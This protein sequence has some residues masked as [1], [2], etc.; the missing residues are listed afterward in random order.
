MKIRIR[1]IRQHVEWITYLQDICKHTPQNLCTWNCFE[2]N[3]D[4]KFGWTAAYKSHYLN[5]D[6]IN[7]HQCQP[8][9]H[10]R[11]IKNGSCIKYNFYHRT[12]L[13]FTAK[14]PQSA[15]ISATAQIQATLLHRTTSELN[16]IG[17]I[18]RVV[19]LSDNNKIMKVCC[20]FCWP[21]MSDAPLTM[22]VFKLGG[23]N[24]HNRNWVCL[25]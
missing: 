13:I 16:H 23:Q 4:T 10:W 25:L 22:F 3:L 11:K 21:A 1:T 9:N 8:K 17:L 14:S 24:L 19:A 15:C 5:R 2:N 20:F 6:L 12:M 18:E 7:I